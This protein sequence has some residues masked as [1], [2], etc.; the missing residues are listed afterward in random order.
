M[1]M[2]A[3][4]PVCLEK[5]KTPRHNL[6]QGELTL[7]NVSCC[8]ASHLDDPVVFIYEVFSLEKTFPDIPG[9]LVVRANIDVII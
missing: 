6:L 2:P 8:I 1:N 3:D 5:W 4:G 7:H 9:S